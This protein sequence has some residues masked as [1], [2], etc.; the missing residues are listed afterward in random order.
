MK[1]VGVVKKQGR[2][3]VI[4]VP[5]LD[6]MT[7]GRT[8]KE[9]LFMIEEAVELVSEAE[10][11]SVKVEELGANQFSLATN[12]DSVLTGLMI[13]RL[14]AKHKTSRE[15]LAAA[16]GQGSTTTIARYEQYRSTPKQD[17]LEK[18]LQIMNESILMKV[19]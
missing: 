2:Y 11:F 10:G 1:L 4:E 3:W 12:N 16:L 18:I 13:K 8:K 19:G 17:Q 7:Q 5:G 9:A 15:E 6:I 14:R